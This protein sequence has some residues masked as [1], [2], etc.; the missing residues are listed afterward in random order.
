MSFIRAEE[1]GDTADIR[2]VNQRAF[3]QPDEANLV[4]ALR[5]RGAI[6]LSLIAIEDQSVVGH[7]LFTPAII[8]AGS[9]SCPAIA[10]GPMAVLPEFQ[11]RG[12]GAQLV[13][14]GLKMC[15]DA[16]HQ[17]VIVLGHPQYYPRFGFQPARSLG[18]RCP[19]EVPDDAFMVRVLGAIPMD[20]PGGMVKYQPEFDQL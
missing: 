17:L 18:I 13:E 7:I 16:G 19:F 9:S 1:Q 6:T 10:L 15:R 12:I 2:R 11:N 4:D 14:T 5:L 3:G 20:F 8:E